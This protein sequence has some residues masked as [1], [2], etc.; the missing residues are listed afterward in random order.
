MHPTNVHVYG[1]VDE[2][3]A[4]YI[5]HGDFEWTTYV[6]KA[7]HMYDTWGIHIQNKYID[8]SE[9]VLYKSEGVNCRL[10]VADHAPLQCFLTIAAL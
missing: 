10:R 5:I 3:H 4:T 8:S 6:Y 2:T 1:R 9:K 7:L